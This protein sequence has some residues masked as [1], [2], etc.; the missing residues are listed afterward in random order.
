MGTIKLLKAHRQISKKWCF[1]KYRSWNQECQFSALWG[2]PWR[3]Y[4][5]NLTID[6]KFINKRIGLFIHQTVCREE[7]NISTSKVLLNC[8]I[9][10]FKKKKCRSSHWRCRSSHRRCCIRKSILKN[11][12]NFTW[13][14][15]CRSLFLWSCRPSGCKLCC[16]VCKTFKNTYFEEHLQTT[17]C[18][19]VLYIKL[20]L[21]TLQYS[22]DESS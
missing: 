4:L 15:L 21:K 2:T 16:K 12:A 5:E 1:E 17:A 7:K 8:E 11:F 10:V 19:G 18:G 9:A 13:K 3:S 14:Q 6:D 22:Q 20:F